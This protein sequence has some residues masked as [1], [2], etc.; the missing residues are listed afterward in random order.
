MLNLGRRSRLGV[1]LILLALGGVAVYT[2]TNFLGPS[3]H[4]EVSAAGRAVCAG[5]ADPGAFGA[6]DQVFLVGGSGIDHPAILASGDDGFQELAIRDRKLASDLLLCG[7]TTQPQRVECPGYYDEQ[8]AAE[9]DELLP[10]DRDSLGE[11][12]DDLEQ[13]LANG[14]SRA[15]RVF[16]RDLDRGGR[17][18][19]VPS[20]QFMV[21][22]MRVST[23]EQLGE[24]VTTLGGECLDTLTERDLFGAR[25]GRM[26]VDP[27]LTAQA[28]LEL[29]GF[30]LG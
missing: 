28:V 7:R 5:S 20:M 27:E 29:T 10:L 18:L 4:R 26:Q 30:S 6:D 17:T 24:T 3:A 13:S 11:F 8:T 9:F 19:E 12:V 22:L 16:T 21:Q 2:Q 15:D 14:G 25:P 1:V 23:G